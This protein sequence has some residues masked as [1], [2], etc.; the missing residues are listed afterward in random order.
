MACN[1]LRSLVLVAGVFAFPASAFAQESKSAALAV[2]LATLLDAAK[3]DSIAA[4]H[5]AAQD[6]FVGALYFPGSQLLVVSAKFAAPQQAVALL[7]SKSYRDLYIDL[8]SASVAGSK[9]FISDLGAD[10]LGFKRESNRPFDSADIGAKSY[11]FDGDWDKAKLSR[12]EYTKAWETADGQ[13]VQMLQSLVK[14][15]KK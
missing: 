4:Q 14:V 10:G 11:S 8:N 15:L 1:G 6:E 7:A 3:L 2:E 9:V 13:Y 12:D 5:G